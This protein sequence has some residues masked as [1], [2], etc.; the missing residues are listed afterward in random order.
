LEKKW[1]HW[2]VKI[3][4]LWLLLIVAAPLA[5]RVSLVPWRPAVIGVAVAA[6]GMVLT[7]FCS[8][9]VLFVRLRTNR[10]GQGQHCLVAV[11]L[12]LLPLAGALY[13][14]MQG[15]KVPPIHDISTDTA[16]PPLFA[17]AGSLRHPGDNRI[18][19]PGAATA[20][21]QRQAY[22]DI[23]PLDVPIPSADAFRRSLVAATWLQWQIVRQDEEQGVI[24]AVDR[25]PVFGFA[26]DIVIRVTAVGTGSRV[27]IRSA[28]RAGVSDL[29]VNAKRIK[30]FLLTFK[31]VQP[32]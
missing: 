14:G 27:D 12:S 4:L 16:N 23:A 21:Q 8:L 18:E 20:D 32:E 1:T 17:K 19:Y 6:G 24:E 9:L 31:E 29:G 28:S 13:F 2:L 3:Q 30:K 26:D 25:T 7:G 15:A 5:F 22:P 11:A 10:R